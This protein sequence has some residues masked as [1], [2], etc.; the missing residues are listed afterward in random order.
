MLYVDPGK[1]YKLEKSVSHSRT[2]GK[3]NMACD[4]GL[5]SPSDYI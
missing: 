3:D 4:L 2:S 1:W 5:S